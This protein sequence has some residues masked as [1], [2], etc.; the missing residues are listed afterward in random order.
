[1]RFSW[2]SSARNCSRPERPRPSNGAD[3]RPH[4]ADNRGIVRMSKNA[5]SGD[6][7]VGPSVSRLIDIV[8]L[9]PTVDLDI[10]IE[11]AAIEIG[12]NS[13]HFVERFRYKSLSAKARMHA[14]HENHVE[15][16]RSL[17]RPIER[18]FGV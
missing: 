12:A 7:N 16:A 10:Q 13:P 1:M 9:D 4:R 17:Q 6:K 5:R 11:A 2:Q 3:P 15:F 18:R 14:H 8:D